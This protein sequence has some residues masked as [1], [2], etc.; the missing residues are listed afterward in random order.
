MSFGRNPHEAKAEAAEQKAQCAKDSTAR[1]Q[2]WREAARQWDRAAERERDDKRRHQFTQKAEAARANADNP[3]D[4]G[5]EGPPVA[6]P[7]EGPP[8]LLN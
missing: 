5:D 2:S 7:H 1:E 6:G 4:G 8:T 3:Q